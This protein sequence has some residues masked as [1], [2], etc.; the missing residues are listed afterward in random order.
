MLEPA[1]PHDEADRLRTLRA[2]SILDTLAEERFDRYTRLAQRLFDVPIALVSLVDESRQWFKSH[3]GLDAS[4]TPRNISFC[5]HAILSEKVLYVPNTLQDERFVDNPLVTGAPDIRFYAG[6][7]LRM[8]NGQR[9]GT[10]CLIDRKPRDLD[11]DDL[12]TLEDLARMVADEMTA[13][14]LATIDEL[15]G[16][17]N[18]RGFIDIAQKVLAA[19]E[20]GN[21]P[22]SLVF[23]DLDGFK[24]INDTLGHAEGDRALIDFATL[25]L[26]VFRTSDVIGRLGGD[27]FAVLASGTNETVVE[28]VLVRLR[29]AVAAFNAEPGRQSELRFSAGCIGYS[30]R[31]HGGIED[32]LAS[33]DALMYTQKNERRSVGA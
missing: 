15:T 17:S 5:G 27:E 10:L 6:H 28:E 21:R 29:W 16:L 25:L 33:A 9:I 12:S 4:E 31:T 11:E 3:Q 1:T 26:D 32:L 22:C 14:A 8:P 30:Q 24:A 19:C 23:I 20:R 2:L 7:P 13:L 18:R